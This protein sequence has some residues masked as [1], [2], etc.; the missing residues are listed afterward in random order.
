MYFNVF[1]GALTLWR[2]PSGKS[3]L[4]L[5][6]DKRYPFDTTDYF[7]FRKKRVS[8]KGSTKSFSQVV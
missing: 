5:V 6:Q 4:A 3:A 8:K 2:T 1:K 7:P